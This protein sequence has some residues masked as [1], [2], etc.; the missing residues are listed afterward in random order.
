MLW[1]FGAPA[2]GLGVKAASLS[3]PPP[4]LVILE[5]ITLVSVLLHKVLEVEVRI[6]GKTLFSA[7]V[8]VLPSGSPRLLTYEVNAPPVPRSTETFETHY[9]FHFKICNPISK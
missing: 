4:G 5:L 6:E 9:R 1:L 7:E 3:P 2:G 8:A